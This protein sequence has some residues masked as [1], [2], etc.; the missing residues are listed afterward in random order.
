[1]LQNLANFSPTLAPSK[2]KPPFQMFKVE[3]IVQKGWIREKVN[4]SLL[5]NLNS[6]QQSC[7]TS[8]RLQV[9]IQKVLKLTS[10]QI[11]VD[12]CNLQ[13]E[14][15]ENRAAGLILWVLYC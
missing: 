1:M 14:Q 10:L 2:G 13:T 8:H 5:I 4:S 6:Q 9:A 12:A 11:S 7:I 15:M 3:E